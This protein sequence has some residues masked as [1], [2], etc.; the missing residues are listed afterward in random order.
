MNSIGIEDPNAEGPKWL[1]KKEEK[2]EKNLM[3]LKAQ[4]LLAELRL[5]TRKGFM[6]ILNKI[7]CNLVPFQVCS[8]VFLF[9]S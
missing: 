4:C 9:L 8:Y 5:G 1:L 7:N 2:K 6:E 3:F